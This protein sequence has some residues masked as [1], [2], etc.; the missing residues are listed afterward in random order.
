[1][2]IGQRRVRNFSESFKAEKVIELE[3]GVTRIRELV[4]EYEI[5]GTTVRRWKVKFGKVKKNPKDL[6][7]KQT[8]IPKS[9][10]N[11]KS[12]LP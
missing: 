12:V 10:L 1:M 6:S 5:S 9:F 8:V 7:L 11:S 3:S 2:S 4:E